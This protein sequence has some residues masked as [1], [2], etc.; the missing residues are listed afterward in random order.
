MLDKAI[1]E[2]DRE[3]MALQNQEKKVI[4]EIKKTAKQGQMDAVKV[5]AKSLVRNRHA[6]T[7][8]YALKSQ[9]QAV[10]LRIQTLKST[11]AMAD[12]MRGATKAM[13]AMNKQMNLPALS[14][15]M[16]EF[17]RQNERMEMT[18]EMMGDAVDDAF[19]GEDEEDESNELVSQ[20]LDE[21][22]VN[23]DS[24]LVK[25][26]GHKQAVPQAAAAEPEA[27]GASAAV[28]GDGIDD[29]LQARLN[30][31]RKQ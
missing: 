24:E 14:N 29:D 13:G 27:I 15:I 11:Q 26:P 31:L 9:L 12:A 22:G 16:R 23:L 1:R 18:S 17:D 8:M 19:E 4:A 2:L 28:G 6:V 10:S 21:I 3:R 30:N 25:A 20:V 7:K 5:M